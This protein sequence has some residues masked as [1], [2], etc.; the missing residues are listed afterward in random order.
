MGIDTSGDTSEYTNAVDIWALGSI[1]HELLTQVTPFRG[2]KELMYCYCPEFPR[3]VMLSKNISQK[4]IEFVGNMLAYDPERRIAAK[5]ALDSEWLRPDCGEKAGLGTGEGPTPT[6]PEG[7]SKVRFRAYVATI[8]AMAWD[9]GG[10]P[11]EPAPLGDRRNPILLDWPS[12]RVSIFQGKK[13][14]GL[15]ALRTPWQPEHHKDIDARVAQTLGVVL[16]EIQ[17]TTISLQKPLLGGGDAVRMLLGGEISTDIRDSVGNTPLHIV[18][19]GRGQ[20][21]VAEDMSYLTVRILVESGAAIDAQ[22]DLGE[23]ALH[24]TVNAGRG[25][26][27]K[28]LLELRADL[29]VSDL[30]G[31][32]PLAVAVMLNNPAIIEP[33]LAS[34]AY[35]GTLWIKLYRA[36][37]RREGGP[38]PPEYICP[39]LISPY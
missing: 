25:A 36:S 17:E 30:G 29:E 24:L 14:E 23:T 31:Y 20:T 38:T 3:K 37:S 19:G 1:Y 11:G 34:G 15:S 32:R 21:A 16:R 7:N 6:S 28:E 33:F 9:D 22:N 12:T 8:R 4:G 35:T 27:V 39:G 5:E 26:M 10:R 18:A 13:G 2:F